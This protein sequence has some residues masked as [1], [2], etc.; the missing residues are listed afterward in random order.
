MVCSL[1]TD[2]FFRFI[3]ILINCDKD[4]SRFIKIFPANVKYSEHNLII[5][6][7]H[8][9]HAHCS[10]YVS[11]TREVI[12]GARYL[13]AGLE[14]IEGVEVMGNPVVSCVGWTS[15]VFNIYNMSSDLTKKGWNLAVLQF[16]AGTVL[17]FNFV[18]YL[19]CHKYIGL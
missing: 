13:I 18:F 6:G 19:L 17:L 2:K 3:V 7:S 1:K 11:A 4:F 14:K 16:P 9:A 8:Y 12:R 15:K 10:G 5:K